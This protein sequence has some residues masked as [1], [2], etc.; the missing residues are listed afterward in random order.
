MKYTDSEGRISTA[1]CRFTVVEDTL[2]Y[3]PTGAHTY[4][5]PVSELVETATVA[6]ET[7]IDS[8]FKAE[9]FAVGEQ[10]GVP[11]GSDSPYYHNNAKWYSEQ[12]NV[13]DKLLMEGQE[14]LEPGLFYV[15]TS[16]VHSG[17]VFPNDPAFT[18]YTDTKY[19]VV[20]DI[21]W[22]ATRRQ[23]SIDFY[24]PLDTALTVKYKVYYK[25]V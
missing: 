9:G 12:A 19:E 11:V 22:D 5:N 13:S 2:G 16:L 17:V 25:T 23:L 10:G 20:T 18:V 6:A 21:E 15:D 8:S 1:S 3:D 14:T 24:N 7:A 4:D